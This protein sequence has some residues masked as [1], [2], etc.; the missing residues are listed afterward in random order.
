MTLP[1]IFGF[2]VAALLLV[3]VVVT[4]AASV[5]VLVRSIRATRG[6]ESLAGHAPQLVLFAFILGLFAAAIFGVGKAYEVLTEGWPAVVGVLGTLFGGWLGYRA[7]TKIAT[8]K[9]GTLES[10]PTPEAK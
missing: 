2:I 9:A 8:T 5:F 4:S 7:A 10:T 6:G 3:L 1:P